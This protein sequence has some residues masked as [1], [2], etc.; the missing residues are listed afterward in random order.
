M[1]EAPDGARAAEAPGRKKRD[2]DAAV[3]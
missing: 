2:R 3:A 1:A